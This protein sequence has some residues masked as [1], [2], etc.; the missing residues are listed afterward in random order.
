VHYNVLIT[1][2]VIH[3]GVELTL[4]MDVAVEGLCMGIAFFQHS[5]ILGFRL[6]V[7]RVLRMSEEGEVLNTLQYSSSGEELFSEPSN[8]H[9]ENTIG[10]DTVIVSDG[11]KRT[12]YMLDD[13]LQLLQTFQL[14]SPGEP[15]G[16][17]AVGEGQVLVVDLRNHTVRLLNL[18][19]GQWRTLLEEEEELVRPMC[20]TYNQ[21]TKRVYVGFFRS[22]EIHM[23][24]VSEWMSHGKLSQDC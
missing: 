21:A 19:T 13:G 22:D 17:A 15:C 2:Q 16:L 10:H 4:M 11:G 5:F 20:L 14:T 6:P 12:V 7:P 1:I 23:Y 8:I 18:T 9:I 24:T 3:I